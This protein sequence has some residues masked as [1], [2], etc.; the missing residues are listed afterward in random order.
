MDW[1]LSMPEK[2]LLLGGS[3]PGRFLKDSKNRSMKVLGPT[4]VGLTV[5]CRD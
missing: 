2:R 4:D 3:Q 5:G 1:G